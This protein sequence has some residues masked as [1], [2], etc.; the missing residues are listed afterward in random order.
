MRQGSGGCLTRRRAAR[1]AGPCRDEDDLDPA[2]AVVTPPHLSA[3]LNDFYALMRW[4]HTAD[5]REARGLRLVDFIM[6]FY[7]P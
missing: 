6:Q 7:A 2:R 4:L 1:R 5:Q 3:K